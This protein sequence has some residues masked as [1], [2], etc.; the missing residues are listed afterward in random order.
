MQRM[1]NS[2]RLLLGRQFNIA[3][4]LCWP[5]GAR[6]DATDRQWVISTPICRSRTSAAGQV[7]C[8][9]QRDAA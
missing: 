3:I 1:G 7:T 8:G 2:D 4:V 5:G 6:G 9:Y